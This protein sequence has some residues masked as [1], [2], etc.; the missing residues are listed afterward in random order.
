MEENSNEKIIVLSTGRVVRITA[1]KVQS[2]NS[3]DKRLDIDVLI[4]EAR[5]GNFHRPIELRHPKYWKLKSLDT[6]RQLLLQLQ[7]SGLSTRQITQ[8]LQ[9]LHQKLF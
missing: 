7:Y 9:E 6:D 5:E 4:R 1:K 8:S 2:F 3:L